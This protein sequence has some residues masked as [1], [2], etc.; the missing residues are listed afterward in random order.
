[1]I[2]IEPNDRMELDSKEISETVQESSL[3]ID[4]VHRLDEGVSSHQEHF[5]FLSFI[6]SSTYLFHIL[7]LI[8]LFHYFPKSILNV[9]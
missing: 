2:A 6:P 4:P 5:F 9:A 1:M 8:F 3:H 7:L